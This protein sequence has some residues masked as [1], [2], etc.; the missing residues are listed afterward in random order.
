MKSLKSNFIPRLYDVEED[1][2]ALYIIMEYFD[3]SSLEISSDTKK[4]RN[5]KI[6]DII[7]QLSEFL[8]FLHERE[9]PILYLDWK[10]DNIILTEEGVKFIDFGS[11]LFLEEALTSS[12]LTTDGYSA[13]ELMKGE[14]I[15][16]SADIYGF[17]CLVKEFANQIEEKESF[18]LRKKKKNELLLLAEKCMREK[19]EKRWTLQ[20]IKKDLE[21]IRNSEKKKRKKEK[22]R[23][24]LIERNERIIGVT[25]TF[26]GV[27]VTHLSVLVAEFLSKKGKSVAFVSFN[28]LDEKNVFFEQM[29]KKRKNLKIYRGIKKAELL[30]VLNQGYQHI[31]ID[32]GIMREGYLEE[33]LRCDKKLMVFQYS[34]LRKETE[35]D[36]LKRCD[37]FLKDGNMDFVFNLCNKGESQKVIK[38]LRKFGIKANVVEQA[39]DKLTD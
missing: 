15:G 23:P 18:F 27:G 4:E 3:P 30:S 22:E 16:L 17:G 39:F 28:Q 9:S 32:F 33:L 11:A 14:G 37:S 34:V 38:E 20:K 7:F 35:I 25:G 21:R 13:P 26:R 10:P 29:E 36:I 5:E 6:L 19:P 2:E 31:V 12:A 8:T 1:E 24:I